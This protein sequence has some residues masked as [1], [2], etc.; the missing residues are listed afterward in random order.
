MIRTI[1]LAIPIVLSMWLF[2]FVLFVGWGVLVARCFRL[3]PEYR[4]VEDY[5]KAFWLG[6]AYV[7]FIMQIWHLFLPVNHRAFILVLVTSIVGFVLGRKNIHLA[8]GGERIWRYVLFLLLLPVV[9][10]IGKIAILPPSA[11]DSGL[12]H[13]NMVR[14]TTTYPIVPGLGNLHGRL[15]FNN[16]HFLYVALL[17]VFKGKSHHF[18]NGLL[19]SVVITQICINGVGVLRNSNSSRF[20]SIVTAAMLY[21][22]L[23]LIIWDQ[24]SSPATDL[25]NFVLGIVLVS[26]LISF[27]EDSDRSKERTGYDLLIIVVLALVGVTI[28]LNFLVLGVTSVLVAL[29]VVGRR[30]VLPSIARWIMVRILLC[31]AIALIPWVVRSVILSGYPAYPSA[32]FPFPVDWRIPLASA[33][34]MNGCIIVCARYGPYTHWPVDLASWSWLGSWLRTVSAEPWVVIPFRLSIVGIILLLV[35][36]LR[37]KRAQHSHTTMCL[38]LVPVFLAVVWWFVTAPEPAFAGTTLYWL[39]LGLICIGI[40]DMFCSRPAVMRVIMILYFSYCMIHFLSN[41]VKY[42][43]HRGDDDFGFHS[44]PMMQMRTFVTRSGLHLYVPTKDDRSW[45]SQ[46]P[47]TPYPDSNLCL[48]C[49]NDLSCG[50]R[51]DP[52]SDSYP[53]AGFRQ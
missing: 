51:I 1:P 42:A 15:A 35:S 6:W 46:L 49:S 25:P 16:S 22:A 40:Y 3:N 4:T 7:I 33:N 29:Y 11:Y 27:L 32:L 48:R 50:F 41:S 52:W 9:A 53:T 21:P 17:E 19:L 20:S 5:I 47:A 18:A 34:V 14:W 24:V 12:Y 28:R 38:F 39:G 10:T 43:V 30:F 37:G 44:T 23:G 2:L 36:R 13:L 31:S 26:L 45:D 8:L